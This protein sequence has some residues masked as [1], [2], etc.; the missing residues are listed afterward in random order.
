MCAVGMVISPHKCIPRRK[1][2]LYVHAMRVTDVTRGKKGGTDTSCGGGGT[3]N[4]QG[5]THGNLCPSP[6]HRLLFVQAKQ[7]DGLYRYQTNGIGKY[8]S[9]TQI[10]RGVSCPYEVLVGSQ[11]SHAVLRTKCGV[12]IFVLTP[13]EKRPHIHWK[14]VPGTTR[15]SELL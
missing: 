8:T 14:P 11:K 10:F 3:N 9:D 4:L 13:G 7:S 6:I 5:S 12:L 1:V 2:L 15:F